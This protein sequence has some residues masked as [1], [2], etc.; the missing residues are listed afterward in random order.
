MKLREY[1]SSGLIAV[2]ALAGIAHAQDRLIIS[3]L[4]ADNNGSLLDEDGDRSDWIEIHNAGA[5]TV[6]LGG[7]H[8]T[9]DAANLTQWTFPSTN[10]PPGGFLVVFASAKNRAVAG[11]QLHTSFQLNASGEYLALVKP[12]GIT[13]AHEFA[14]AFPPQVS[15]VSYGLDIVDS[16]VTFVTNSNPI[17]W[18]V[19]LNAGAM[20]ADWATTNFN[21]AAWS[22]GFPGLGYS[23]GTATNFGTLPA[24]NNVARS[25]PTMQSS[26]NTF[27]PQIAVNGN[28]TDYTHTLAGANLPAT[29]EV[30]LTTNCG[31]ERI[32]LWNRTSNKSRLRDITVR[33]L[34]ADGTATNYTSALLNPENVLGGGVLNQGPD[35]IS[36]NLTQQTGALMIGGRV[37]VT[38]TPDPDRSGSGGTG[39]TSEADVLALAEVEVFGAGMTVTTGGAFANLVQT[40][41]RSA[42]TNVNSTALMRVPFLI[43][44]EELPVLDRLTLRMK[45]DDGFIAYL[46]GVEI[47]RR[48]SPATPAWNSAATTNH[49]DSA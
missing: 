20:P 22:S 5:G 48:N 44:E 23:G 9:D 15:G 11:A 33:I 28:Y 29:W 8:L 6:N 40:D 13:I 25:K 19:P 10:L 12:N 45:Y 14:P 27:G 32:V 39:T 7:W 38:R 41:I 24:T 17:K 46:N 30:N 26:T 31:I 36:I 3:E 1:L 43:P 35:Q 42:M 4:V 2:L 21:D 18:L 16:P 34:S 47:A 37:R 49:A